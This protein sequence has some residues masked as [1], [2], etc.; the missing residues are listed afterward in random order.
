MA[1]AAIGRFIVEFEQL[2]DAIRTHIYFTLMTNGLQDFKLANN[3]VHSKALTAFPLIDM[4]SSMLSD[5]GHLVDEA[6]ET[7]G[8]VWH[9]IIKQSSVA[10]ERRNQIAH[11]T[12]F[13]GWGNK[14]TESWSKLEG[15]KIVP[16][17][18]AGASIKDLGVEPE[19]IYKECDEIATL[20][21]LLRKATTILT[22]PPAS[23]MPRDYK[24]HFT[25]EDGRWLP[26]QPTA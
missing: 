13:I 2:I 14:Q 8:Q 26:D 25:L 4:M 7:K 20:T 5:Q 12:W 18:K 19:E 3:V 21:K 17:K 11:G 10:A 24:E 6:D 22:L 16:S 15:Y 1:Y 23:G 9:Y